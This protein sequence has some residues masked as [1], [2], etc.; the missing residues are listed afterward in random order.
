MGLAADHLLLEHRGRQRLEDPLA[1][2]D[3]QVLVTAHQ[4]ADGRIAGGEA[5]P[6]VL[7][8]ELSGQVVK[9]PGRARTP[10]LRSHQGATGGA[11]EGATGG[12]GWA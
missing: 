10:G 1:P 3:P 11:A 9:Q 4:L 2:P 6:V 8:A 7:A 12:A 5:G